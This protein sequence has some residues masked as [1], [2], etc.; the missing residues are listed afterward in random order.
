MGMSGLSRQELVPHLDVKQ[1]P[2]TLEGMITEWFSNGASILGPEQSTIIIIL[3]NFS[4]SYSVSSITLTTISWT[5]RHHT[6]EMTLLPLPVQIYFF[7]MIHIQLIH[8]DTP[9]GR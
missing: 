8:R 9:I 3:Y 2:K 7:Y 1:A 6:M 4:A 5:L